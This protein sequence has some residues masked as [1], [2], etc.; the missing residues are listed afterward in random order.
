[1]REIAITDEK[2]NEIVY[3]LCGVREE[4]MGI[5]AGGNYY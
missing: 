2:T 3:G 4:E 1:V 5:I